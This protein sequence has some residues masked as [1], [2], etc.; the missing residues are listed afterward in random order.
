MLKIMFLLNF[1]HPTQYKYLTTVKAKVVVVEMKAEP[2][3]V[4]VSDVEVEVEA[5]EAVV[6][7]RKRKR[8]K[9]CR[10]CSVSKLLL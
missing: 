8:L 6:F 7:W 1:T 2:E 5:P 9:I 4:R 3:T 10:F